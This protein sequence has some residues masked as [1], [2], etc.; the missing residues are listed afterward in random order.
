VR[1]SLLFG[2]FNYADR[3]IL[4]RTHLHF[5]TRRTLVE[6]LE[7]SGLAV[8]RIQPTPIPLALVHPFF[9]TTAAGRFLHRM[10]PL[11]MRSTMLQE[12]G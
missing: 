12:C 6:F 1:L 5:F 9:Q 2:R 7:N 10:L 4:D 11:S 8:Q 3:G